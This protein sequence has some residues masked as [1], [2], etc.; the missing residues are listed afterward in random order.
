LGLPAAESDESDEDDK[1]E[2]TPPWSIR[3]IDFAHTRLVEP[4]EGPDEGVLLGIRT[5]G[6]LVRGRV[7]ELGGDEE[8]LEMRKGEEQVMAAV[9][10]SLDQ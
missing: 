7:R 3:M 8:G 5:L 6:E 2:P 1:D 10:R 9:E 4:S